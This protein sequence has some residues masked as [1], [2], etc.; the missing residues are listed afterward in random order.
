MNAR[1]EQADSHGEREDVGPAQAERIDPERARHD[2]GGIEPEG[3]QAEEAGFAPREQPNQ[4]QPDERQR[5]RRLAGIEAPAVGPAR[6]ADHQQAAALSGQKAARR[7]QRLSGHET[8]RELA[9]QRGIRAVAQQPPRRDDHRVV[10]HGAP[11]NAAHRPA[12]LH[13]RPDAVQGGQVHYRELDEYGRYGKERGDAAAER[14]APEPPWV[15]VGSVA[16]EPRRRQ[17]EQRGDDRF[18]RVLVDEYRV[19]GKELHERRGRASQQRDG[20]VTRQ[21]PGD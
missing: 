17:Q 14:H 13:P 2:P 8:V 1:R 11:E 5:P 21:P 10:R 6:Q 3:R 16:P 4:A 18:Q 20:G 12:A 15:D 19:V 7:G 9:A